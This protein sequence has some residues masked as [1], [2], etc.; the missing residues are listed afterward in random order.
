MK[1][2]LSSAL[3]ALTL[4]TI[5]IQKTQAGIVAAVFAFN[6]QDD[7]KPAQTM[8]LAGSAAALMVGCGIIH[9]THLGN[10]AWGDFATLLLVLDTEG[11]N[12]SRNLSEQF[13]FIDNQSLIS[14]LSNKIQSKL[15]SQMNEGITYDLSLTEAETKEI[16]KDSD[17][18][19]E[20]I[21]VVVEELK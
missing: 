11:N 14:E 7:E 18:T 20:E 13:P 19:E 9:A 10:A 17:L 2:L 4:I 1:K 6:S 12:L 21:A 16:L 3:L 5:P 15:P 8:I